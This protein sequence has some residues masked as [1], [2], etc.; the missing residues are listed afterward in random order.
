[1][2]ECGENVDEAKLT[3]IALAEN[4]NSHKCSSY[5]MYIVLFWIFLQLILVEQVLYIFLKTLKKDVYS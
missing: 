4:K 2:E 3:E 1:M 5:V